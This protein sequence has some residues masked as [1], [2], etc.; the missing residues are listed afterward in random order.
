MVSKI[1][2][3]H[4][5]LCTIVNRQFKIETLIYLCWQHPKVRWEGKGSFKEY[6]KDPQ[7]SSMNAIRDPKEWWVKYW[8]S[9]YS[10]CW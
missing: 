6:V 2:W 9:M 4:P 7:N 8:Q 1:Y 10:C 3:V 5:N